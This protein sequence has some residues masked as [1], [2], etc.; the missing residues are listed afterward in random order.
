LMR[1][2]GYPDDLTF[3]SDEV[4]FYPADGTYVYGVGVGMKDFLANA[5][6]LRFSFDRFTSSLRVI[7]VKEVFPYEG[8][9]YM[10]WRFNDKLGGGEGKANY[11]VIKGLGGGEVREYEVNEGGELRVEIPEDTTKINLGL[12]RDEVNKRLGSIF[13]NMLKEELVSFLAGKGLELVGFVEGVWEKSENGDWVRPSVREGM[14]YFVPLLDKEGYIISDW[15]GVPRVIY[16]ELGKEIWKGEFG[17]FGEPLYERGIVSNYIPFRLYGMYKDMETDLYYNVRRYYD[18]RVGRYLQPDPV[19]DLNLYVYVNNSPYDLVDPLGMFQTRMQFLGEL[20]HAGPPKHEEITED[21]ASS[22]RWKYPKLYQQ[23][24]RVENW[25]GGPWAFGAQCRGPANTLAQGV[26]RADCFY[27][28]NSDFHCDNNNFDGCWRI[29][30][31]VKE[32]RGIIKCYCY[33]PTGGGGGS[34]GGGGGGGGG[35]WNWGGVGGGVGKGGG[36]GGGGAGCSVANQRIRKKLGLGRPCDFSQRGEGGCQCT[37]YFLQTLSSYN[38]VYYKKLYEVLGTDEVNYEKLG[39]LLHPIQDFW[40]H[41]TAIYVPGCKTKK[42]VKKVLGV[43]LDEECA[44]YYRN[45]NWTD[46]DIPTSTQARNAG[47]RTGWFGGNGWGALE[48]VACLWPPCNAHCMLNKDDGHFRGDDFS[49]CDGNIQ[50]D[51]HW[52]VKSKA[53]D[54]TKYHLDLFCKGLGGICF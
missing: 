35:N 40:S 23:A 53:T 9:E 5:G 12:V 7:K 29:A 46:L 15:R 44:E 43:C 45:Y 50:K 3:F 51:A 11:W 33:Y 21:A 27:S 32:A 42:C 36:D 13:T 52:E 34:G 10:G 26:N 30:S 37:C 49:P 38:Y 18:W 31:E 1:V 19:S 6:V 25:D 20:W 39:R 16:D 47:L 17:P 28:D 41:S 4:T 2:G 8:I 14:R 48:D 54:S 22:L 24:F